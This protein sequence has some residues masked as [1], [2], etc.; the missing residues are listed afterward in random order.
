MR[1]ALSLGNYIMVQLTLPK[2]SKMTKGKVWNKPEGKKVRKFEVYRWNPDDTENPHVDTYHLDM[3]QCAVESGV[4][5]C[6][7][8]G[9]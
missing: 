6:D 8:G 1:M 5:F 2:N 3:A 9:H 7:L 4:H